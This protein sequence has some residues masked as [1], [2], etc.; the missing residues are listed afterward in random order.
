MRATDRFR[1]AHL[2]VSYN[3]ENLPIFVVYISA[4]MDTL[5]KEVLTYTPS[6]LLK[7]KACY[8]PK[9]N[10]EKII[11]YGQDE[12]WSNTFIQAMLTPKQECY[13]SDQ[14]SHFIFHPNGK[15]KQIDLFRVDGKM[16]GQ[17]LFLYDAS[18]MIKEE[19]WNEIPSGS[20]VRHLVY[21]T[22]TPP[23]I[24]QV[25]EYDK[26]DSLVS[27]VA[28][29]MAP[30]DKLY[31]TELPKTGNILDETELILNEIY[32]SGSVSTIPEEI[33]KTVWDILVLNTDEVL[34]IEYLGQN[35]HGFI[36]RLKDDPAILIIPDNT[37]KT[38]TSKWGEEIFPKN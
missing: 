8:G 13:F 31:K 4:S 26:N 28:L 15:L 21:E 38:L 12:P 34:E 1:T 30:E 27:H 6:N 2:V 11:E 7:H 5:K 29:E 20:C 18:G 23:K 19:I 36:I 35:E 10:L 25:W 37:V 14:Q 22:I 32:H 24:R 3:E 16:Y 9:G 33:P 17:I